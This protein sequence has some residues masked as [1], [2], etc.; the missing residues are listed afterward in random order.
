MPAHRI[1]RLNAIS[2]AACAVAMLAGRQTLHPLFGLA[3]PALLDVLAVGL[4]AYAA[5]LGVIAARPAIDRAALIACTIADAAW[6]GASGVVLLLFWGELAPIARFLVIAVA[7]VVEVFAMLQF[8]A[9]GRV[10]RRV[11]AHA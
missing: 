11:S 6:V 8:R 4:L 5:T 3:S 10:A 7:V 9:A 1:L 2:T